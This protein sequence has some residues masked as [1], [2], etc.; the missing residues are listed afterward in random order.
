M[1][2]PQ[3][4]AAALRSRNP[5]RNAPVEIVDPRWLAKALALTLAVALLC[6][7]LTACLLFYQGAWQL[8]LHPSRTVDRTPASAGLVFT[9]VRFGDFDT[10][11]PHL[12]GWWIL[13]QPPQQPASASALTI[14]YL[15]DGSGSLSHTVP[16]LTLL[17]A[18]GL[19]IFAI[20]YRGFGASNSS[21]HP[22]ADR[23]A[24]D[25]SAALDYLVNTQHI[26]ANSIVP[27]GNGLGAAL[28]VQLAH[29]HPELPALILDN[30]DPDPAVTAAAHSSHLIPVRLLFGDRFAISAPLATLATPKLL[31]ADG[32]SSAS[33]EDL[34]HRAAD[35][36]YTIT[37][38]PTDSGAQLQQALHRFLDQYVQY[39]QQAQH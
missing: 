20:D 9:P 23:M 8:V 36:K 14:L 10:G 27:M 24:Q 16:A 38:A 2:S 12:T 31:I 17:H 3:K 33:L 4:R 11:A 18:T 32:P 21:I 26:S 29:N 22:D 35:P 1:S 28:A 7:Y 37:L 6:A 13:A 34:Y 19:N 30:P 15:H 39:A 5:S 25:A